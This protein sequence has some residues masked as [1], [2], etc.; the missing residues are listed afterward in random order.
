MDSNEFVGE[1]KP[2][3]TKDRDFEAILNILVPATR[4]GGAT[5]NIDGSDVR[6]PSRHLLEAAAQEKAEDIT[7]GKNYTEMLTDVQ[8]AREVLVSS[9]MSPQDMIST[10]VTFEINSDKLPSE[11][12]AAAREVLDPHFTN[13][14]NISDYLPAAIDEALFGSG[15]DVRVVLPYTA[16]DSIINHGGR[17]STES[18]APLVGVDGLPKRLGLLGQSDYTS[19]T[20]GELKTNGGTKSAVSFGVKLALESLGSESGTLPSFSTVALFDDKCQIVD[21]YDSIK[22]PALGQRITNEAVSRLVESQRF[23]GV[24]LAQEAFSNPQQQPDQS[25]HQAA[26]DQVNKRLAYSTGGGSLGVATTVG[27]PESYGKR[28]TAR[29]LIMKVPTESMIP[30]TVPGNPEQ[31]VGYFLIQDQ[32]GNPIWLAKGSQNYRQIAGRL[33][34][35]TYDVKNVIGDQSFRQMFGNQRQDQPMTTQAMIDAYGS[36]MERD[37]RSRL[38]NGAYKAGVD[39]QMST[40]IKRVMLARK[41]ANCGTM[42][43]FITRTQVTYFAFYYND[44]GF[45][46][47]LMDRTKITATIRSVLLF[48]NTMASVRKAVGNTELK[49]ELDPDDDDPAATVEYLFHEFSRT[50]NRA[51]PLAAQNA[52]DTVTF[53]Q[54]AG[55]SVAVSGNKAYP[56]TRASTEDRSIGN[57]DPDTELEERQQKNHWQG[58]GLSPELIDGLSSPNFAE[59]IVSGNLLMAKRVLVYQKTAVSISSEHCRQVI[60]ADG[61]LFEDLVKAV[62]DELLKLKEEAIAGLYEY[63]ELDPAADSNAQYKYVLLIREM[64]EDIIGAYRVVLPEPDV[65][66]FTQQV[67]AMEAYSNALDSVLKNYITPDMI[68]ALITTE[69]GAAI[70]NFFAMVKGYYMREWLR[71]NNVMP[72][73]ENLLDLKGESGSNIVESVRVHNEQLQ[74]VLGELVRVF[75]GKS[76]DFEHDKEADQNNDADK[77]GADYTNA[78]GGGSGSSD[79]GGGDDF[80]AGGDSFGGGDDFGGGDEFGSGDDLTGDTETPEAGDTPKPDEF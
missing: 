55:V 34:G 16:L 68:N 28:S 42:L 27:D 54:N 40:E 35:S 25:G 6:A 8:L 18:I 65:S 38:R 61:L 52:N 32:E 37:L 64:V 47:S 76:R 71:R 41:L 19:L 2:E 39:I 48:A 26:V 75:A 11:V 17:V 30:V 36:I 24:Y 46:E 77:L 7:T 12:I 57:V 56:E 67:A 4:R 20:D 69:D 51:F 59:S 70:D 13:V 1:K 72:E 79:F 50:R 3:V 78:S 62:G 45:G 23:K 63:Y 21:N 5:Q 14:H 44:E 58:M 66:K 29:P 43:T 31:H 33:R 22:L 9:I 74:S 53:L 10:D 15:A 80:G 49:I 73:L 60:R